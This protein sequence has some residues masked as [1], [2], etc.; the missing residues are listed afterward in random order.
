MAEPSR[1]SLLRAFLA[2]PVAVRLAPFVRP[3]P[4]DYTGE[5]LA[6]YRASLRAFAEK[7]IAVICDGAWMYRGF[8]EP[9][10]FLCSPAEHAFLT[11]GT[12]LPPEQTEFYDGNF[13]PGRSDKE[14]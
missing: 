12:P 10:P 6:A 5:F 1:R 2:A 7:N 14:T 11:E 3:A 9:D 8:E 4:L 13:F